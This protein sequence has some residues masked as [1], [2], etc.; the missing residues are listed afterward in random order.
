MQSNL[1]TKRILSCTFLLCFA[2]VFSTSAQPAKIQP[3]VDQAQLALDNGNYSHSIRIAESAIEESKKANKRLFVLAGMIVLAKAQISFHK[4]GE[5][6]KTLVEASNTIPKNES[7]SAERAELL[8]NFAW[9]F[10]SQHKFPEAIKYSKKA[11]ALVPNNKQIL[12]EHYLNLGRVLFA[13]GFDV[14]AIIW[15]EKAERLLEPEHISSAKLDVYRFLALAWW[16]KSNYQNAL[17]Y[18]RKGETEGGNTQF[19]QNYRQ[20]IFD[21]ATILSE[22][23]QETLA[24][25]ALNKGVALALANG[26]PYHAG[27]F[28]TSLILNSLDSDDL[29]KASIYLRQLE[30]LDEYGS[31][32][33]EIILGKAIFA[34]FQG[35]VAEADRLFS[36]LGELETSS[37]Y[38]VPYWKIAIAEKHQD[39]HQFIKLNEELLELTTRDNFRSGI[40]GIYF[41]LA[42]AYFR[43]GQPVRSGSYLEKC[44][45]YVE[46]IRGTQDASLSLG[47]SNTYHDAYR[48]L[49]QIK[50]ETPQEAFELADLLKARLLKDRIN[51]AAITHSF[52]ISPAVRE[53]LEELSTKYIDG[54]IS[55]VEIEKA[56]KGIT[57]QIPE[58]DLEKPDLAGLGG[59]DDLKETAI[60]SYFFTID[61][62]LL[63]FVWQR[64]QPVRTIDLGISDPEA[65]GDAKITEQ[66]IHDLLFFKKDGKALYDK[67]LRPLNL[68]S[69]H[70]VIIPDKSIWKIPFQALSPDGEK[71]LIESTE[72]S[73]APA[74]SVLLEQLKSPKPV[75]ETVLAFANSSYD[76]Q[77]LQYVN[78]EATSV[79]RIY[80]S[81][82]ILNATAAD[83][84]RVSQRADI[85]HLSMHSQVSN[86]MPLE[87]FLA[88]RPLGANDGRLTV[89][90]I[91][92]IK[93]KKGSLIFLASCDTNN[94]LN[95]EGLVSLSWAMMGSGATTV[96]SAQWEANDRSTEVFSRKYYR[97]YRAGNSASEAIRKAAIEMINDK[98]SNIHEPYYWANFTVNG[99]FR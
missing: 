59:I 46:E 22:S 92:K 43:L 31:F 19:K 84:R 64:G 32:T 27:I 75:R 79:A 86:E 4:Y 34:A 98:S 93:L 76:M 29:P 51:N 1:K 7:H 47:L 60:I 77:V 61:K 10:R 62:K 85:L 15:L 72:I 18:T 96:I 99:D 21:S 9:L 71:Y 90:D 81:N 38:V 45:S 83:F 20:A 42:K 67:F 14:S 95:G 52:A 11:I 87:S 78:A 91:L 70:L 26:N 68:E 63:A 39:W 24:L 30:K 33:F 13:S 57:S 94:V 8:I 37:D 23:G 12:A 88:F 74:V 44:L 16:A 55:S 66:K 2:F 80:N 54:E 50:L 28:L 17:K 89:E 48:L 58:L 73:Y 65:D 97:S 53:A 35:H 5:A 40:P 49:A 6:L 69:K 3:R 25:K 82:P 41:N 36:K 56:E